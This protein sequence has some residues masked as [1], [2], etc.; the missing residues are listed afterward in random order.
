MAAAIAKVSKA[1]RISSR[2]VYPTTAA[3][4]AAALAEIMV[5]AETA[6][7]AA[8]TTTVSWNQMERLQKGPR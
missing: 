5:A 2:G 1:A 8:D 4:V 3:A 7:V 6:A